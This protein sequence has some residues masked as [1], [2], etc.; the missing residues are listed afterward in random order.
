MKQVKSYLLCFMLV[1]WLS[2][3]N[4]IS[5]AYDALSTTVSNEEFDSK[6]ETIKLL[7]SLKDTIYEI[8]NTNESSSIYKSIIE[9]QSDFKFDASS[10]PLKNYSVFSGLAGEYWTYTIEHCEVVLNLDAKKRITEVVYNTSNSYVTSNC[11]IKY[12]A[13]TQ[14]DILLTDPEKEEIIVNLPTS[15]KHNAKIENNI[16]LYLSPKSY[17]WVEFTPFCYKIVV[18][19]SLYNWHGDLKNEKVGPLSRKRRA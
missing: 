18:V 1:L 8:E 11:A 5:F 14:F 15:L 16:E 6:N 2:N 19:I 7:I 10:F 3:Y 13:N 4:V 9:N 17:G 12:L